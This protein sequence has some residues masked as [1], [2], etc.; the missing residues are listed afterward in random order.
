M[1]VAA[2]WLAGL[3]PKNLLSQ[4]RLC[5]ALRSLLAAW[6]TKAGVR[7]EGK[8]RKSSNEEVALFST[9]TAHF[10]SS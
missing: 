8:G 4:G 7:Q 1:Q 6:D 2:Q 5:W 3:R 10:P 9:L